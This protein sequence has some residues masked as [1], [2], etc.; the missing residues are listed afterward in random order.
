MKHFK[1]SLIQFE[2]QE[3]KRSFLLTKTNHVLTLLLNYSRI[4]EQLKPYILRRVAHNIS[5]TV[6]NSSCIIIT[7]NTTSIES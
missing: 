3:M 7:E 5:A 2:L 1:I 6:T 4:G